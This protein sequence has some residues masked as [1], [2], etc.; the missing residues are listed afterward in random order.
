M[1]EL[2]KL[3]E[4]W[5][6]YTVLSERQRPP[7][8][9]ARL[10]EVVDLLTNAHGMP[11]HRHEFMLREAL[12]TSDFPYLFGDVLDRQVLASYKA[13]PPV[14]QAFTRRSTVPRIYPQ[15]GGYRFAMTGGDQLLAE[16]PEKGEYHASERDEHRYPVYVR[17]YG[18]QFDISWEALINDD[19]GAL[20]DTPARFAQ[21]AL[22]TE[23][24]L[25]TGTYV[26]D[27][28]TDSTHALGF[29]YDSTVGDVINLGALPLTIANLEATV[30]AMTAFVDA[31]GEPILNRPKYLVVGP[32]LEFTARQILTSAVKQ[33]VELGGAGGPLPFP[34]SN[35]IAQYGLQLVIDPYIPIFAPQ[36]PGSWFL[37]ADPADI[38]AME[39]DYLAGH[40]RP[41]VCMKSSD[42]V[43]IG[44]GEIGPMEGDFATDNVF[45]RVRH[46][47]GCNKLDWRATYGQL[48]A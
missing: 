24:R 37:F 16:V 45:Y 38:A 10:K 43:N 31:N 39:V 40:E 6:G 8:Y 3:M 23:C 25:V 2:M 44:G 4:D 34:T 47:F 5:R 18:R 19:L 32:A 12:T 13:V 20:K 21:A 27:A 7:N 30:Q 41:E 1:P 17:K 26:T 28:L 42:K 46:V 35:V 48:H 29:L 9:E 14:F 15:I 33:W 36:S 11:Q 22:R